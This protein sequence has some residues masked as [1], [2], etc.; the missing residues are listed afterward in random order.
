[1]RRSVVIVVVL[2]LLPARAALAQPA[3][4]KPKAGIAVW[5][6]G[7]PSAEALSP[8]A[9]AGKNDWTAIPPEKTADS[10]KGDAVLSNGR[11][12]AVLRKQDAAV[13]VH[14]VKPDGAVSRLRLRLQTASGRAGRSPGAHGPDRKQQ[15][16]RMSGGDFKT[17]KGAEVAGKFRLKRGDVSVQA[18][19]GTGAGKLRVECA[20]PLRRPAGFL[21]R[22]H[23]LDAT[24]LP[25]NSVELPSENFVLHLMGKGDAIAMCVFENRQQD[26]KVTLAGEGEKRHRHRLGD[27]LRGQEGL[28]GAAGRAAASGTRVEL[29]ANDTGKVV[30]LDWKMPFPAQW[31]VDFTARQRPDRQLGNAAAREERAARTPSRPGWAAAIEHARRT[32][33]AGTRCSAR[34][35]IPAGRT[36]TARAI[37]SRSRARCCSSQGRRSSIRSTASSRRRSTPSPWW[38]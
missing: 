15:E 35:P 26:V 16:R 3:E 22:R 37:S 11:I 17:A 2:L 19:P 10:F 14:A 21:R 25:L 20:G 32:A 29:K 34:F 24:K 18:E 9:L 23:H 6:T 27:R 12:V 36:P 7:K 28:G 30:P 8:A 13:E 38:T 1:M 4:V 31:R 5:D 33:S